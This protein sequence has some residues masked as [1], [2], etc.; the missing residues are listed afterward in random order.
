LVNL[1]WKLKKKWRRNEDYLV[2]RQVSNLTQW[3]G[4]PGTCAST[5]EEAR[6]CRSVDAVDVDHLKTTGQLPSVSSQS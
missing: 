5:R 1:N 6:F 3:A 2:P 4:V